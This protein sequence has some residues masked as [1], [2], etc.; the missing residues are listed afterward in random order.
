MDR[1][2]LS[3]YDRE[4]AYLRELGAEF[5]QEYPKV[6]GQLGL[7]S[8]ACSD[9]HVE[10]L[11]EGFAFLA[12]RVQLAI[13]AEFPR[14]TEQL[15]DLIYP[16]CL[17]PTPSLAVV[18]FEPNPR[19]AIP[20]NGFVLPRGTRLHAEVPRRAGS[21]CRYV[22]AHE[23]TLWPIE[24]TSLSHRSGADWLT[25]TQ[26]QRLSQ[27]GRNVRGSLC[28]RLR[29]L[30]GRP[31]CDLE[32]DRLP[33]F[34]PVRDGVG[35]Q[36]FE[37]CHG[38]TLGL[39]VRAPDGEL[40]G[41]TS[42]ESVTSL[43][44]E[45]EHAL[46]P[47]TARAFQGYRLLQEYFAL[48]DRFSFVELKELGPALRRCRH[49]EVELSL[50]LD[51]HDASVEASLQARHAQLF[52]SP[53]TNLFELRTDRIALSERS[54]EY[55]VVPDRTRPL[56]YEVH[57]IVE[58]LGH[59]GD[60]EP[61]RPFLP[62]YADGRQ[63][64]VTTGSGY[65]SVQ[66]RP[67]AASA[68]ERRGGE[69]SYTGSETYLSLADGQEGPYRPGLRQLSVRAL[70]TN[71]DLPLALARATAAPSFRLEVAS[72]ISAIHTLAGPSAPQPSQAWGDTCWR[73]ITRLSCN[74][75]SLVGEGGG[76]GASAL[77]ELLGLHADPAAPFAARQI[78]GVRS[79]TSTTVVRRLPLPG[80]ASFGRGLEVKLECDESAF[81]G[82]SVLA[83]GMVLAR[84]FSRFA[85]INS[86][87]ELVL[88][89]SV[90]GE[91]ARFPAQLGRR[92]SL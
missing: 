85:S 84:F 59:G 34:I 37:L 90:R 86:F 10:R 64:H 24:L 78:Q 55:H 47:A 72:P 40:L 62:F 83:F 53:I 28:L 81:E 38:A 16:H 35:R 1:R 88:S 68:L 67:R 7:S 8:A 22:T 33:L 77:R 49:S 60:N 91:L 69:P 42:P 71:R 56:D 92:L 89:G 65:F 14:F 11:L 9:P 12:A 21:S 74:Y 79:V 54:H 31:F 48:P 25:A 63:R 39:H 61:P 45:D 30:D 5:A 44:L 15:L 2:L 29:T 36:L 13:D 20:A 4:L 23:V 17:A 26:H 80:P 51:R 19:Q 3:H 57:S 43:G 52:C 41:V 76:N 6:A 66:R 58:V 32:L 27:P 46:L 75:L 18:R 82:V 73:L 87:T 50:L 70:C